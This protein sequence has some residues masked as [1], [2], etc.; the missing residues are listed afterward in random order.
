MHTNQ[1]IFHTLQRTLHSAIMR[2]NSS[3]TVMHTNQCISIL[4]CNAMHTPEHGAVLCGETKELSNA[5]MQQMM[6][7]SPSEAFCGEAHTLQ[8]GRAVTAQSEVMTGPTLRGRPA[9]SGAQTQRTVD[10][11]T[12]RYEA[13]FLLRVQRISSGTSEG[14]KR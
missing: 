14:H 3:F 8:E 10:R 9:W 6:R 13:S 1:C 4:Q 12:P 2:C 7:A 11:K 5:A